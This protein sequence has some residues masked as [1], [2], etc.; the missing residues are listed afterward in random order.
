M[1]RGLDD[2]WI[3][4]LDECPQVSANTVTI[5]A[6]NSIQIKFAKMKTF[7][8]RLLPFLVSW[9]SSQTWQV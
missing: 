1:F 9:S 3:S 4:I 5:N 6:I 8:Y 2:G 7:V